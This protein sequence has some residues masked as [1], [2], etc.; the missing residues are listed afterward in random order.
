[1][2]RALLLLL[3]ALLVVQGC[4]R[5]VT[6]VAPLSDTEKQTLS[7]KQIG[8]ESDRLNILLN[9]LRHGNDALISNDAAKT[10]QGIQA[11]EL[12]L[13]QIRELSVQKLCVFG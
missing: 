10:R 2:K 11:A 5:P 7:C 1:M 9:Q 4:A 12:R 6:I 3:P 8:R 13:Q